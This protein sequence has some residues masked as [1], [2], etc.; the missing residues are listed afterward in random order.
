MQAIGNKNLRF[1]KTISILRKE[2]GILRFWKGAQVIAS[3][4]IPAHAAYFSTYEYLKY[5]LEFN[6]QQYD[7]I[8]TFLIGA[9]STFFHD[10]FITPADVVK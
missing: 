8:G 10:F 1:F 5:L 9:F 2:E 6:N 7:F 3:G 4:C